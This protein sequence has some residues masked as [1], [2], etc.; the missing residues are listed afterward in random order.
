M[1]GQDETQRFA[2]LIV[3][4]ALLAGICAVELARTKTMS[5]ESGSAA[6]QRMRSISQLLDEPDALPVGASVL[7]HSMAQ[8]VSQCTAGSPL[9]E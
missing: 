1:D 7:M 8:I 5:E 9:P 4:T 3:E 2:A 6:V